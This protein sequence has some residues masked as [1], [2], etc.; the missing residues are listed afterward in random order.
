M[1]TITINSGKLAI[2]FKAGEL[3]AIDPADPRFVL[4]LGGTKIMGSV[5][6]KAARKLKVHPGGA[7]LQGRLVVQGG[8][9]ALLDSGFA[10][11]DPKPAAEQTGGE[12]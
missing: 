2:V 10:W 1:T 4:D 12:A 9:L 6:A 3:P 11:I 8:A 5:N 7:V